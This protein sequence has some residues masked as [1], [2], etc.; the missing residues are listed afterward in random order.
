[1]IIA[2][3]TAITVYAQRD[4][5]P[6]SRRFFVQLRAVFGRFRESD[7]Q[8]VFDTAGPIQCSQLI[9]DKGE[10]RTV[11]FFNEKR[12]LGDWYRSNFEEVKNDLA[13]FIFKGVCRGDRGPVQLTTRFPVSES[14]DS[15]TQG[16]IELGEVAVNVNAPVSAFFDPRSQKYGFELPY[17]F[18][19]NRNED[20]SI[21]SLN[22][23]HMLDRTKYATDVTDHWECKSVIA[24]AVTYQFL[25]CRST[26]MP[27]SIALRN[28]NR[29]PSFGASAYF[30]LS[31]GREAISN[32]KLT[33]ND[34]SESKHTI[35]D[36]SAATPPEVA[37][38]PG[39]WQ[40][41][42]SDE[43]IVAFSRDQFRIRFVPESWT[44]RIGSPQVV[45]EQS[46]SSLASS[47]PTPGADYCAWLPDNR[48]A[49]DLLLTPDTDELM[50]YTIIGRDQER[51]SATSITFDMKTRTGLHAGNLQCVF[52]RTPSAGSVTYS[53]WVS[54]VGSHLT[55]EIRP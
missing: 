15:Y 22:P 51:Q 18:L 53:R 16:K 50:T 45:S 20:G 24:E 3:F 14:I 17:L 1:M 25:I 26:T 21:Y 4:D 47:I 52:P 9:N 49:I 13:V 2:C 31:D 39:P 42:D 37:L 28:Q 46:L 10:W 32:V 19:I 5:G 55:L 43:R 30:I 33:F 6:Y 40:A 27:R 34:A 23:P 44:G 38:A 35:E 7:L 29:V 12:E 8:R 54:I 11:A 41:P 36:T 48:S